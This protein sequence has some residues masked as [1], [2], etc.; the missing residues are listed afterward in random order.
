M[1]KRRKE[2]TP[3]TFRPGLP[4]ESLDVIRM[5][6]IAGR[7]VCVAPQTLEDVSYALSN[8][9]P[10]LA[11]PERLTAQEC[12]RLWGVFAR[13]VQKTKPALLQRA[14]KSLYLELEAIGQKLA[15]PPLQRWRDLPEGLEAPDPVRV[16]PEATLPGETLEGVRERAKALSQV[17]KD[18]AVPAQEVFSLIAALNEPARR[19][20]YKNLIGAGRL[21]RSDVALIEQ[22]LE[23][24]AR[25]DDDDLVAESLTVVVTWLAS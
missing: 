17:S 12:A 18:R 1:A 23:R 24:R 13:V 15:L 21:G 22:L 11:T 20:L 8:V 3:G 10:K 5:F 9:I 2:I 4:A 6:A 19:D 25:I 7:A 16:E 14:G